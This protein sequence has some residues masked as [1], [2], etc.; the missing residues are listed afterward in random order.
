MAS[1]RKI[2]GNPGTLCHGAGDGDVLGCFWIG[3]VVIIR[4]S[5]G[6]RMNRNEMCCLKLIIASIAMRPSGA[7]PSA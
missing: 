1:R 7:T 4:I 2:N 3:S 6:K 5:L